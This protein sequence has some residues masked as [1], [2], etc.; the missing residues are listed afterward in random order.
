MAL[1]A[2]SPSVVLTGNPGSDEVGIDLGCTYEARPPHANPADPEHTRLLDRDKPAADWNTTTGLNYADQDIVFDLKTG[3]RIDAVAVLFDRPQ[4][5][6]YVEVF[7]SDSPDAAWTA[8]GRMVKDEQPGTW[9]R[10]DLA[11]VTTR[12]VKLFHKLDSWGWYLREAR[13]YG[14]VQAAEAQAAKVLDGKLVLAEGG[15]PRATIVLAAAASRRTLDAALVVQRL[16][17]RMTSVWLPIEVESAFDGQSAAIYV[18]DS[19]AVRTRGVAVRQDASEGDHYV[20][21]RG[22]EWLALVGNDAPQYGGHYL[23]GSVY[24]AYH[25]F[26]ALGCG[27]YGPEP[28]WQVIPR[29]RALAVPPLDVDER[30]AFLWRHMWMHRMISPELR[31][32]WR[33]GG[34][35]RAGGHAYY[36]LVPP[37]KYKSE[38]PDW[39]GEGQPD[40]THPEVIRVVATS[41]RKTISAVPPPTVVPF[42][43]S[44]NDTGGF[45]DNA[46]TRAIGNISAQQLYFA[47]GVAKE[48]NR[49]H[50]GRFRLYCLAYWFSHPAPQPMLKAEPGVHITIVNEGNHTKPL[51][52]PEP[53]EIVQSTGRNNTRE[54]QAI[55]GWAKT[56]AL[57]GIYEWYIPAIGNPVWADMPW[58][59]G[60]VSLRNLRFWKRKGIRFVFYES[61]REKNGGFPLRWPVYY[62]CYRGMWD[63]DLTAKEIMA[64]ACDRLY[65]PAADAMMQY[66]GGFETAMLETDEHVGN[67]HLPRPDKVYTAAVAAAADRWLAAAEQAAVEETV[68]QRVAVEK[69]LWGNAKTVLA[70]LRAA[71]QG[72]TFNVILDGKEMACATPKVNRVLLLNLFGLAD[73]TAIEVVEADGQNRRLLAS[74]TIDLTAG[75]V[76]RTAAP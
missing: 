68:R 22:D 60:E 1:A 6:A 63:P 5:P 51:D 50:P 73:D 18:G 10:L 44:A 14:S 4:K 56:G 26:E 32:A 36:R 16:A 24:A 34:V 28:L 65:G 69:S 31:D 49:T 72:R 67:W 53:P 20:I 64:E 23:R 62:Q 40:I 35:V 12:Y 17:W 57:D 70:E 8:V 75:V 41:L 45:V 38:H 58:H 9:W 15:V 52:L 33:E 13:I 39:F 46:R 7:V 61:Q 37:A 30:P 11:D 71:E 21:R 47:N 54:L 59:P 43:F 66:Y 76:F 42:S 74:D 2:S 48:L 55:D 25:L 29:V 19:S 27:W 3:C